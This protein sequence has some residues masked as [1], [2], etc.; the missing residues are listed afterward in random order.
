MIISIPWICQLMLISIRLSVILLLTPIQALRQVPMTL[1]ILFI[2]ILSFLL[3]MLLTTDQ[4]I[5]ESSLLAG[6]FTECF[7][8]VIIATSLY[9]AFSVSHIAAQLID[10][11]TGLN[12]LAVFKPDEHNQESCTA[13]LLSMLSVLLFFSIEGHRWLFQSLYYSF[14]VIPP[15]TLMI[16][17]GLSAILKQCAF[18]FSMALLI[19]SPI[20]LLLL[21]IDIGVNLITRNMPQINA[22]F[23]ALPLK[24][25]FGLFLLATLLPYFNMVYQL[26]FE[27][28]FQLW[29]ELL[30]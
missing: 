27:H 25:V 13:Q 20:V 17:Q 1:R 18:M 21:S 22:Y 6:S 16:L 10:N 30:S 19:A 29:V 2:F 26:I 15:G 5:H 24:I 28:C 8:G 23:I 7:N 3:T 14:I 9:V 4:Q 11:Q 12:I